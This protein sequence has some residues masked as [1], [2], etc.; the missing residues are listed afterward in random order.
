LLD[1]A[2]ADYRLIL[3]HPGI[4][5]TWPAYTLTH[6]YLARVLGRQKK[7]AEARAEYEVFLD[8]WKNADPEL[9]QL[10]Q[11]RGEFANLGHADG[12]IHS[13]VITGPAVEEWFPASH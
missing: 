2:A 12:A 5:P 13:S 8:R 9:P 6:L 3:A 1:Q 11:A 10:A 4:E 7:T